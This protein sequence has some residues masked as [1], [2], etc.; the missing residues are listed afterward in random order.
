MQMPSDP[1]REQTTNDFPR[2]GIIPADLI[3]HVEALLDEA[4]EQQDEMGA[5][6]WADLGVAD[7]EYRLS[8]IHPQEGPW[9]VVTVGEASPGCQL[10]G[11]LNERLDSAR[12]PRTHIIC[13]W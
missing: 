7:V 11:W 13:E 10:T 9:C 1:A 12:F 4:R 2:L 5:V 3:A 8:V 6:N